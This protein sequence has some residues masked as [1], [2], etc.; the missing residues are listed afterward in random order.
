MSS[1]VNFP[2]F[3][4]KLSKNSVI[5]LIFRLFLKI[6]DTLFFDTSIYQHII[7]YSFHS[8]NRLLNPN[9]KPDFGTGFEQIRIRRNKFGTNKFGT[10]NNLE[11]IT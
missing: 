7:L 2:R 5:S 10:K 11:R 3:T 4:W 6:F 9:R 1:H 8:K